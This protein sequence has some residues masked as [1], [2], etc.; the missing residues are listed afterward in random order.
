M[1]L[2]KTQNFAGQ[3]RNKVNTETQ[4]IG[5]EKKDWGSKVENNLDIMKF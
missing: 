1:L 4:A 5:K 3:K 2:G